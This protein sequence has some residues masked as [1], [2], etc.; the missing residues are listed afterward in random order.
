[1][2]TFFCCYCTILTYAAAAAVEAV[3]SVL[4]AVSRSVAAALVANQDAVTIETPVFSM[5]VAR[6]DTKSRSAARTAIQGV[7]ELP[8]ELPAELELQT[9]TW[10][11]SPFA[12]FASDVP[13]ENPEM[14][15]SS[16]VLTVNLYTSGH[17]L[18][19]SDLDDAIHIALPTSGIENNLT[20]NEATCNSTACV[21]RYNI[22]QDN[23]HACSDLLE[24][25]SYSCG[26][27]FCESCTYSG[28]CDKACG[29]GPCASSSATDE[30]HNSSACQLPAMPSCS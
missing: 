19:I 12:P 5:Q 18:N 29:I 20:D 16:R 22:A 28:Y 6:I 17:A 10:Q 4:A 26:E 24:S 23:L 13:L 3:T 25:R 11:T 7:V 14:L 15:V 21:D 27:H 2:K 8:A 1:M 30:T 9:I